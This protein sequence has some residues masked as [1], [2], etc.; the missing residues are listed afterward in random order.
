MRQK[1][2]TRE[3]PSTKQNEDLK[4]QRVPHDIHHHHEDVG[5]VARAHVDPVDG[6]YAENTDDVVDNTCRDEQFPFTAEVVADHVEHG[7]KYHADRNRVGHVGQEEDGL[8]HSLQRPDRVQAH[9][10]DECQERR[11][12]NGQEANE[13]G[14]AKAS[15]ET[16]VLDHLLEVAKADVEGDTGN[17]G[18]HNIII[19]KECH[20]QCVYDGPHRKDQQQHNGGREID[21]R[22]PG[23]L[24][25]YHITLP[26]SKF[27][28]H[29]RGR[30]GIP[31]G[32]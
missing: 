25:F 12:R 18:G 17:G 28:S 29:P 7:G 4:G 1:V 20:A 31:Y 13:H 8:Q 15:K 11:D 27:S 16:A 24:T 19:F 23:M 9:R 5:R 14:V 26:R 21:P 6:L 32:A 2:R 30:T 3:V 10:N 22:L